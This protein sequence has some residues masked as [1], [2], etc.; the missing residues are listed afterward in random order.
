[1]KADVC[2]MIDYTCAK[3][4]HGASVC[5]EKGKSLSA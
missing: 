4:E 1:M 5:D 3:S 2:P